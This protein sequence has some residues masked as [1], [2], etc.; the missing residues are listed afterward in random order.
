M[1]ASR[2]AL[3]TDVPDLLP[4][5]SRAL[6]QQLGEKLLEHTYASIREILDREAEG[7]LLLYCA[8]RGDLEAVRHLVQDISVQRLPPRV[9]ILYADQHDGELLSDLDSYITRRM[10]WPTEGH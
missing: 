1:T 4:S 7:L 3:V 6:H 8:R 5:L 2:V 9:V 10:A